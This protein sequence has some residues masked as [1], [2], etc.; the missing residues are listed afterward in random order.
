MFFKFIIINLIIK[1]KSFIIIVNVKVLNNILNS[2]FCI[3][4]SIDITTVNINKGF[5]FKQS[6]FIW[7]YK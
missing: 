6:F 4:I 7:I 2:V 1:L 5:F 3:N